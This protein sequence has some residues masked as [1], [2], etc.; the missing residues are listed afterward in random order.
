MIRLAGLVRFLVDR[1]YQCGALDVKDR[2]RMEILRLVREN[3][4]GENSAR[5]PNFPT[6]K[7]IASRVNTHREAVTRE[8]NQLSRAGLI[9]QQ[10]RVLVVPSISGFQDLLPEQL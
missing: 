8:L 6:H 1:V 7:D 9:E 2:I 3:L 5:I 10:G 4:S